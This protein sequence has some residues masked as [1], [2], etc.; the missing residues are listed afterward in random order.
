ML[1]K[2]QNEDGTFSVSDSTQLTGVFNGTVIEQVPT[3]I[4]RGTLEQAQSQITMANARL[5]ADQN[6]VNNLT[7]VISALQS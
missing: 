5:T 7:S 6:I 2:I 1:T 4:F 3:V